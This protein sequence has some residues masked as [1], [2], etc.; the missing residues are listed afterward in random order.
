MRKL[1][2][3]LA[4]VGRARRRV[5]QVATAPAADHRSTIVWLDN[6]A[7]ERA[8]VRRLP[9]A[10]WSCNGL[11][12]AKF[13]ATCLEVLDRFAAAGGDRGRSLALHRHRHRHPR[14]LAASSG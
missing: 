8:G 9:N 10:Y 7:E 3:G 14:V 1:W 13:E 11:R 6:G 5:A 4:G 2:F 12:A